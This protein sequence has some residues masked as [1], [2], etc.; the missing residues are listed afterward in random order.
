MRK[1]LRAANKIKI[2]DY[3]IKSMPT[4][5]STRKN[6]SLSAKLLRMVGMTPKSEKI[7][8]LRAEKENL[9]AE[10][11]KVEEVM[12]KDKTPHRSLNANP[13]LSLKRTLTAMK[14]KVEKKLN[15]SIG[16]KN[17]IAH[18]EFSESAN[19]P[20]K[21]LVLRQPLS[22]IPIRKG[23]KS[24][25]PRGSPRSPAKGGRKTRKHRRRHYKKKY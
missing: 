10:I 4:P 24:G 17:S 23:T 25:S 3:Y 6:K 12:G 2:L 15:K 21:I 19:S 7:A 13:N 1:I 8:H 18:Q 5:T 14:N 22:P 9:E 20:Q 16:R 11:R